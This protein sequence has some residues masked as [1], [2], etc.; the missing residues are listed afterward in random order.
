MTV[1]LM[2]GGS[3]ALEPDGV[4]F[5]SD[6]YSAEATPATPSSAVITV[7]T[8]GTITKNLNGA[9]ATQIGTWYTFVGDAGDYDVQL[10][11]TSGVLS[12]TWEAADADLTMSTDRLFGVEEAV[13]GQTELFTG[14]LHIKKT[15]GADLDTAVVTLSATVP[16]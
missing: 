9:G 11:T 7:K 1:A 3:A 6:P 4:L 8:D 15:G 12:G 13:A 2:A 5:T 16:V 14:V 10:S